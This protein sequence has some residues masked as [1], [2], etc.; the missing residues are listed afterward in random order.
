MVQKKFSGIGSVF[1][2]PNSLRA[3]WRFLLFVLGIELAEYLL[4]EPLISFLGRQL[5]IRL[6]ELSAPSLFIEELVGFLIVLLVT[7]IAA[8]FERRRVDDYGLPVSQ[9]FGLLFW[10][11]M[12][13]GLLV[14]IF[15]AGAMIVSGAMQVHGLALNGTA[16]L[17]FGLL[18]LGANLL[19]GLNEEYLFRGYAL[20]ALWRGAGFWPAAIVTTAIFAGLHM[21]K[22]H[23]NAMDIGMI[24]ILGLAICLSVQRTG[25]LWWAVGWHAAFDFGQ[26]FHIGTH[27]GGQ[28]PVG[29]LLA[30]TFDGPALLNGGELGTEASIF[31]V[32]AAI[33]TFIYVIWFLRGEKGESKPATEH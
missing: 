20:Q 14:V 27:N 8:F 6:D 1:V 12:L 3:G 22:P 25:T 17:W 29:H 19:V 2:G 30:V 15:V 11:G 24:F 23:E 16:L 21:S 13:A 7:G 28:A 33:A 32:P 5:G 18:W 31:M 4:R 10:K 26:F 9:A